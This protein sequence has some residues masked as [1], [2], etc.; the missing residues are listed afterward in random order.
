MFVCVCVCVCVC[1]CIYMK[2]S[3]IKQGYWKSEDNNMKPIVE[4]VQVSSQVNY[5]MIRMSPHE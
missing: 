2:H 5:Q 4:L 3:V 1:L